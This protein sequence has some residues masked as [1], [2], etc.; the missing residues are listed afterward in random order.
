MDCANW[1]P[2]SSCVC[3]RGKEG[4]RPIALAALTHISM[5]SHIDICLLYHADPH[6]C[7]E[8][9]NAYCTSQWLH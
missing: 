9:L 2:P 5:S 1:I 3:A 4:S 7:W 8:H 6:Q